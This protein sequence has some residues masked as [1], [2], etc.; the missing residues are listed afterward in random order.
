MEKILGEGALVLLHLEVVFV[1]GK[2]LRHRDEFVPNI[3][4]PVQHLLGSRTRRT[5]SLTLRLGLTVKTHSDGS[6]QSD[7]NY[8]KRRPFHCRL[9]LISSAFR[10]SV[11]G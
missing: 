2:I 10:N 11:R 7:R 6:K 1:F 4:P 5:R 9:L 3:V 8:R